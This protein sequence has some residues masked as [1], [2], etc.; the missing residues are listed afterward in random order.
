MK[1]LFFTVLVVTLISF[2]ACPQGKILS[3]EE[4]NKLFGTVLVSKEMPSSTLMSLANKSTKVIMFNVIDNNIYIMDKNRKVLLPE[5]FAVSSS[6]EFH[7]FSTSIVHE[8]LS[9]GNNPVT[10]I[11]KRKDVLTITNGNYTLEFA[12]LCPPFCPD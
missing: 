5:G 2:Y 3:K 8:L 6:Q 12:I 4:A 7:V 1:Q 9:N 11:E 10:Y